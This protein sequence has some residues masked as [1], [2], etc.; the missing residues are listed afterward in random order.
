[1]LFFL[2]S[3]TFPC[4]FL[5]ISVSFLLLVSVYCSL[6]LSYCFVLSNYLNVRVAQN[7]VGN[8]HLPTESTIFWTICFYTTHAHAY[9]FPFIYLYFCRTSCCYILTFTLCSE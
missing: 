8:S 2:S 9:P 1:M 5:R 3:P 6:L 7:V 4:C